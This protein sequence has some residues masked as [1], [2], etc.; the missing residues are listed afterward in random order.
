MAEWE[1]KHLVTSDITNPSMNK[2]TG[3]QMPT[4]L[5]R[6]KDFSTVLKQLYLN[7]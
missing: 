2:T 6:Y 1:R 7:K 4:A 3:K 5:P